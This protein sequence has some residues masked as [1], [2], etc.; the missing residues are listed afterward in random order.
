[1]F[2]CD[3][4]RE[5]EGLFDTA[6]GIIFGALFGLAFWLAVVFVFSF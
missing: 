1:M 3:W 2:K 4:D 5:C 6:R